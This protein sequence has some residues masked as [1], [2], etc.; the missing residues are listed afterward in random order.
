MTTAPTLTFTAYGEK[1]TVFPVFGR[2]S[3]GR[4]ALTFDTTDGQGHFAHVSVNMPELEPADGEMFIKD[5]SE[6]TQIV[7]VLEDAGW[8]KRT[9]VEVRTG[10]VDAPVMTMAGPLEK[11]F[12]EI[13]KES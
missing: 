13:T 9:G 10:Y 5:W 6:S 1:F 8:L 2:Y 3:N 11:F 4:T 7:A 12:N